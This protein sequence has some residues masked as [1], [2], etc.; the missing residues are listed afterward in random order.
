MPVV[1]GWLGLLNPF[2][3]LVMAAGGL[4]VGVPVSWWLEIRRP[5]AAGRLP[6][7][8]YALLGAGLGVAV[9]V[10]VSLPWLGDAEPGIAAVAAAVAAAVGA[11]AGVGVLVAGTRAPGWLVPVLAAVAVLFA[12]GA[13]W[14]SW[15]LVDGAADYD[16]LVVESTEQADVPFDDAG[17]LG[18]V[19][20]DRFKL[21]A[22]R[23]RQP[24]AHATW[25]AVGNDITGRWPDVRFRTHYEPE[26]ARLD[27]GV[28]M[29]L[30]T[31]GV[32]D[33]DAC[34][35]VQPGQT[36]VHPDTN[37]DDDVV[38]WVLGRR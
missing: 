27:Q 15:T 21:L 20:A 19:V 32:G 2:Y 28:V 18:W 37:C 12:A 6:V 38:E 29:R 13:G 25:V 5:A 24:T 23:G 31:V 35:V 17:E 30:I 3:A 26:P 4:L 14:W 8:R 36:T 22:A 33:E 34:V 16:R 11:V 1:G 7:G 9:P 10:V